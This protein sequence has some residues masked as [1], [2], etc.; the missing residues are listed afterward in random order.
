MKIKTG[1]YI[2]VIEYSHKY[3]IPK[4]TVIQRIKNGK[5]KSIP[6]KYNDKV[7]LYLILD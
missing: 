4:I 6:V 1:N 3:N 7:L 2:T 5:I